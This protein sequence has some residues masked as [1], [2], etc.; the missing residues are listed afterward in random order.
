MFLVLAALGLVSPSYSS[1]ASN[2]AAHLE[3][4]VGVLFTTCCHY[5]SALVLY[6]LGRRVLGPDHAR[7][8]LC[9]AL[10][11]VLSPAGLFLSAPGA[12]SPFSLLSF[13]GWL[14]LVV[15][16]HD[17][18]ASTASGLWRDLLTLSSGV[19]FGLATLFRANGLLNGTPFAFEFLSTLYRLVEDTDPAKTPRYLRSLVVLGLS[20][21]SVAAGSILPQLMAY[22]MYCTAPDGM[23]LDVR[24]PWCL[25][26]IPSIYD[27]VQRT[28]WYAMPSITLFFSD[29]SASWR[30]EHCSSH[31]SCKSTSVMM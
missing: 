12:E 1:S 26:F 18:E 16:C 19:V 13:V 23:A 25:N 5:L 21:L 9:A 10:L 30:S 14:L 4:L 29:S 15:S 8:A 3:A 17:V 27:Y 11:H 22:R 6:Q 7:W 28:Y 31:W 20:G 24:P 2:H